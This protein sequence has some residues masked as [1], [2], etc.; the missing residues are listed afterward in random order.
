VTP[1]Q[2]K[3]VVAI[4]DPRNF[5]GDAYQ[6][7]L[8]SV[9]QAKGLA[10]LLLENLEGVNL[11]ARNAELERLLSLDLSTEE[12]R[13]RAHEWPS[14]PQGRKL[15]AIQAE[16]ENTIDRLASLEKA[17]AYNPLSREAQR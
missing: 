9:Q 6:V 12:L 15:A 17:V 2:T 13:D 7:A 4:V 1:T 3:H 14:S 10:T 5:D 11:M 16:V 8:A